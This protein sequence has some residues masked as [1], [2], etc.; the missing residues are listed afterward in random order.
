MNEQITGSEKK[1][2]LSFSNINPNTN[3][4][5]AIP[6]RRSIINFFKENPDWELELQFGNEERLS[7]KFAA[8][9]FFG[10]ILGRYTIR[11]SQMHKFD[12]Q[13]MHNL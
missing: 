7:W 3:P 13:T 11:I 1:A 10:N 12:Q 6:L 5:S 9:L 4:K 8:M 2:V